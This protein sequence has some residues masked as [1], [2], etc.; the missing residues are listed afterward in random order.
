M[1]ERDNVKVLAFV[2]EASFMICT[3]CESEVFE[4]EVDD[5]DPAK[6]LRI[7][8]ANEECGTYWDTDSPYEAEEE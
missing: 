3:E 4:I 2:K 5:K 1:G 8:C 7:H 6:I